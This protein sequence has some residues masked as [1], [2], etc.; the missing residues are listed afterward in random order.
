MPDVL[1]L[2]LEHLGQRA[3][4]ARALVQARQRLDGLGVAGIVLEHLAPEL[5]ADL[6]LAQPL[7]GE[8]RDLD[9][10]QRP[11][12]LVHQLD[13]ERMTST[14]FSQSRRFSYMSLRRVI[15]STLPRSMLEHARVALD[16]LRLVRRL[17]DVQLAGAREARDLLGRVLDQLGLADSVLITSDQRLRPSN[18]TRFSSSVLS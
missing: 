15:A 13:L 3:P 10:A 11:V 9:V 16:G 6:G 14:S 8:V 2:R 1:D 5:D 4:L 12:E 17:L 7:R 18:F